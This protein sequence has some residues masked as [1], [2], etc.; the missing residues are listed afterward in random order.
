[1]A[2][3]G[4]TT[5]LRLCLDRLLPPVKDP[6]V[7]TFFRFYELQNDRLREESIAPLLNKVSKFITNPLLRAV[8]GTKVSI[9]DSKEV[10]HLL[11]RKF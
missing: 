1:M 11:I 10:K 5:A 3:Q 6:A 4:D 8:I 2:L 7:K 9:V